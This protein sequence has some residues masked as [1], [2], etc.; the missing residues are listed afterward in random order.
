M[1][2][3]DVKQ[4]IDDYF[5]NITPEELNEFVKGIEDDLVD[6]ELPALNI[7]LMHEYVDRADMVQNSFHYA[8]GEDLMNHHFNKGSLEEMEIFNLYKTTGDN[9]FELYQR[10]ADYELKK[11]NI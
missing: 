11:Y 1:K 4:K 6:E 2:L 5:A 3:E 7:H 9:L 8:F 10:L